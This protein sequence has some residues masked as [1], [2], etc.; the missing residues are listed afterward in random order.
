MKNSDRKRR[1]DQLVDLVHAQSGHETVEKLVEL[2]ELL[3]DEVREANDN[4]SIDSFLPN[5]GEIRAYTRVI[6]YIRAG[7][8]PKPEEKG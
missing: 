2:L 6:Q 8:R 1:R 7:N 5:Q 3:R 4:C